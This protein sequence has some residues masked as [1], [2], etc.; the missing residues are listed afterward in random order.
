MISEIKMID[1]R[2]GAALA[3][4]LLL[5]WGLVDSAAS[6]PAGPVFA[7]NPEI[8]TVTARDPGGHWTAAALFEAALLPL[9]EPAAG[10]E[11]LTTNIE[12]QGTDA[13]PEVTEN[14]AYAVESAEVA[15]DLADM[16]FEDAKPLPTGDV[17]VE[18]VGTG[19]DAYF[20]SSRL[21]PTDARLHFPYRVN[22]KLYFQ[23]PNGQNFIC[24]GTVIKPRLVLTAG[25]CV[26][27]GSGGSGGFYA[28]FLFVP[29]YHQGQAP[30]QAWNYTYVVTTGS[31]STSNGSVPNAAD[32]AILEAEDRKFGSDVKKIGEVVGWV[33]YRTGA[34]TPNHT[35]KVG[36]PGNHDGGEIMHQVDSASYQNA[37]ANTV[38]YGSDMRGGS[39]GGGWFENF[40]VKAQ[41]QQG[42]LF[43]SP[44]RVIGVTSYG[45]TSTGPKVQGSSILN[46][47]FLKILNL[48]CQHRSGNC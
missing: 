36:Y 41:G 27:K 46:Q 18:A 2:H 25:H 44:N 37:Q 31:W 1:F 30:Y 19:G 16:L 28:K 45:Y 13:I 32:F 11:A 33:G 14:G 5:A 35:K 15:P 10:L 34:L 23:K 26:H 48:A 6:Q 47:E 3:A 24:S 21:V 22:G 7:E 8:Q 40:G 12:A 17:Q 29:A 39:S 4:G 9:P 43:S 42:A 20:S 38:L